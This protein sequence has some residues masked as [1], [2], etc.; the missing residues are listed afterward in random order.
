MSWVDV[1]SGVGVVTLDGQGAGVKRP[2]AAGELDID[3]AGAAVVGHEQSQVGRRGEVGPPPVDVGINPD[4]GSTGRRRA[5][6]D[7]ARARSS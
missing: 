5:L 1:V 6:T 7:P 2:R 4:N 3:D